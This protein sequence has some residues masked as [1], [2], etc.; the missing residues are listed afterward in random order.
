MAVSSRLRRGAPFFA[1]GLLVALAL[2]AVA[3]MAGAAAPK[4]PTG[5]LVAG[6]E[7]RVLRLGD[8]PPGYQIGD[9][10]AC[11]PLDPEGGSR[12][13]VKWVVRYWP[14]GCTFQYERLFRV[15]GLEPDPP[16]VEAQVTVTPNEPA[17]KTGFKLVT[18]EIAGKGNGYRGVRSAPAIGDDAR[19]FRSDNVNV[20]GRPSR[21]GSL[22]AW[23]EGKLIASVL[24]A[25]LAPAA[26]DRI[27]LRLAQV[28]QG[29]IEAPAPYTEEEQDDTEV[30]LDDP[31]LKV[32]VYWVGPSFE[33]SGLAPAALSEA[34]TFAAS[35]EGPPGEKVSL[36]Y[37]GFT[38]DAWTR[39]SWKRFNRSM[40]GPLNR[41]WRCTTS[42]RVQ[43]PR[44]HADVFAAY[45]RDFHACPKR[46]PDR[47]Y[48]IAH[49]GGMVIGV[50]L[51]LC[52]KCIGAG[53]GPY[54]SLAAMKAIMRAL[55]LRPKPV[56]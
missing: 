13:D 15:P 19:L 11:G 16:L 34:F 6:A 51:V 43:L 3:G 41:K 26:N 56:Y 10:S 52:S 46:A 28:Q 21:H 32:P 9:D 7:E 35:R 12:A 25:G 36:W 22:L 17:A 14:E 47:F 54:N 44:G 31:A 5:E 20:G 40:L 49:I 24:V 2:A 4:G 18:T 39:A 27:A 8:L 33:P 30:S 55:T 1:A 29:R 38:V 37:E 53:Y 23:R 48:A 50:N 42:T 45:G